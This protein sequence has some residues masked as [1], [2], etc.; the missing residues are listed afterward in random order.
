[1]IEKLLLS[2]HRLCRCSVVIIMLMLAEYRLCRCGVLIE[3][4]LL[5]SYRLCGCNSLTS[6]C[7][8]YN[9][10]TFEVEE[11]RCTNITRISGCASVE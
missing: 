11:V 8:H 7:Y 4:L 9:S 2:N 6:R 3:M 1:M 10:L 5:A